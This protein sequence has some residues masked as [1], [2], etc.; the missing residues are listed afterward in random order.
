VQLNSKIGEGTTVTVRLS[1][2]RNK[3]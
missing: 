3:P 1:V 2:F